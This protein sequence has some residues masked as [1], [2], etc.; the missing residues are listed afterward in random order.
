M[1]LKVSKTLVNAAKLVHKV[2]KE[3]YWVII[4][5]GRKRKDVESLVKKYNLSNHFIFLGSYPSDQMP[6]FYQHAD[7]LVFS[8]KK[9]IFIH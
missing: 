6:L 3:V 8:L 5:D 2:N 4:G 7:A 1:R 9:K